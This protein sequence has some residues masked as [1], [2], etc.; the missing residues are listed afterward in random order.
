M[1]I[2]SKFCQ[3]VRGNKNNID[4][5]R[6]ILS[7]RSSFKKIYVM[8]KYHVISFVAI[9]RKE[10]LHFLFYSYTKR[11]DYDDLVPFVRFDNRTLKM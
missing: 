3:H 8:I 6:M 5:L 10:I 11:I 1:H 7:S 9:K 2:T 4:I